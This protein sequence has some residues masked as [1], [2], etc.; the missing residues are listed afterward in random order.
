[1]G[2]ARGNSTK[3]CAPIALTD[4]QHLDAAGQ[5]DPRTPAHLEA[6]LLESGGKAISAGLILFDDSNQVHQVKRHSILC[7]DRRL[8]NINVNVSLV[9]ATGCHGHGYAS[10]LGQAQRCLSCGGRRCRYKLRPHFMV[11][12]EVCF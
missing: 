9:A 10:P 4:A 8:I 7:L 12:E 5:P 3:I 6:N 2:R 11:W 1:M